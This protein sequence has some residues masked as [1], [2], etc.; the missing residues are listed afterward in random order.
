M[1]Y[2]K[3]F[4]IILI[5]ISP[6]LMAIIFPKA[7][8]I[9]YIKCENQYGQCSE[10]LLERLNTAVG[11]NLYEAR[12]Q[13]SK[14]VKEDSTISNYSIQY[15]LPNRLIVSILDKNPKFAVSNK[16]NGIVALI[17]AKGEVIGFAKDTNL[18]GVEIGTKMPNVGSVVDRNILFAAKIVYG[19]RLS[20]YVSRAE[21][22]DN[23]L[24]ITLDEGSRVI[25]PLDGD[26]EVLL[27]SFN[28]LLSRLNLITKDTKIDNTEN[29]SEIDLRFNNPVLR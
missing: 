29:I 21:L 12:T 1:K 15:K 8:K 16:K 6:L 26:Y 11:M 20:N 7:V 19:V 22:K 10:E 9:K 2:I 4:F 25:F 5:S 28:L 23:G 13:I 14:F 17:D 24:F 3:S 18:P 27:G